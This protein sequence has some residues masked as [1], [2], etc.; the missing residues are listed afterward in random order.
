MRCR[1][2]TPIWR[3]QLGDP[4]LSRG[5]L[6]EPK[7]AVDGRIRPAVL[8]QQAEQRS[9][10]EAHAG[11]HVGRQGDTFRPLAGATRPEVLEVHDAR[12]Y[13]AQRP[14]EEEVG[15]S[16][17]EA[18][19]HEARPPG[20][21]DLEAPLHL[22]DH[23]ARR[24]HGGLAVRE[25]AP[26]GIVE[27]EDQ[28]DATV[29]QDPLAWRVADRSIAFERP[30]ALHEGSERRVYRVLTEVNRVQGHGGALRR[31]ILAACPESPDHLT[32]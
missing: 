21:L 14:M 27:V 5:R 9:L 22:A 23:E 16:R 13:F 1:Q 15:P 30:H 17:P 11:R 4:D 26:K 29:G 20:R 19:G 25:V 2:L 32:F 12:R 28:L 31:V 18:D 10:D 7:P 6:D 3:R 24:L 8:A